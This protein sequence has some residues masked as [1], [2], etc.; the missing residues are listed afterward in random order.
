[1]AITDI[2]DVNANE[3][4]KCLN[5]KYEYKEKQWS[6]V[7]LKGKK[8]Y[9][10][11]FLICLQRDFL[12]LQKPCNLSNIEIV[13]DRSQVIK[14]NGAHRKNGNGHSSTRFVSNQY[15]RHSFHKRV[16]QSVDKF[17]GKDNLQQKS[18][19]VISLPSSLTEDVQL[20]KAEIAWKPSPKGKKSEFEV[21][22]V[23]ELKKKVV[24]ILNKLTPQKFQTLVEKFQEIPIDTQEK[25]SM[26][27]ELVF[28]KAVDEPAYR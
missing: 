11:D 8:Q 13:K 19:L 2:V 20:N 3:E 15:N 27:M 10:R 26:C 5:L 25:L 4:I 28:E 1:M 24:S 9:D 22:A 18:K 23:D 14:S 6:P 17:R 7:N 12:S 16:V 21:T